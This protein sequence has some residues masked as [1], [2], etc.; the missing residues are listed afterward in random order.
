M[1]CIF[2]QYCKKKPKNSR[3]IIR[4]TPVTDDKDDKTAQAFEDVTKDPYEPQIY[5]RSSLFKRI[6]G[7]SSPNYREPIVRVAE[8]ASLFL[9]VRHR[10]QE[11]T[12][13][14]NALIEELKRIATECYDK[15]HGTH[16]NQFSPKMI[17]GL[18]L[19]KGLNR[20]IEIEDGHEKIGG[21]L[22]GFEAPFD[23]WANNVYTLRIC[24]SGDDELPVRFV[25]VSGLK[26]H[27][28]S[29]GVK[30]M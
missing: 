16:R 9:H 29:A 13:E 8:A 6:G 24:D 28:G 3:S 22:T 20:K 18:Q 5:V 25:K 15:R 19:T 10:E 4:R 2:V 26:W 27:S 11:D 7:D 17:R 1:N 12:N 21:I 23:K 30:F 14:I